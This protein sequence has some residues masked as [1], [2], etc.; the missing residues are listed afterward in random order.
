MMFPITVCS[1]GPWAWGG[2]ADA[3]QT[4]KSKSWLSIKQKPRTL[5]VARTMTQWHLA[6]NQWSLPAAEKRISRTFRAR[7]DNEFSDTR[8][9]CCK[10]KKH[11]ITGVKMGDN[12]SCY[13]WYPE[14][15]SLIH[16]IAPSGLPLLRAELTNWH[17]QN[18]LS[19]NHTRKVWLIYLWI[20]AGRP[21]VDS[22]GV[23]GHIF[24]DK[25][26]NSKLW[27]LGE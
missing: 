9:T 6:T 1:A 26:L 12:F 11:E 10:I 18:S 8:G 13:Q 23:S 3:G 22:T 21:E 19:M 24:T 2:R 15:P 16:L 7:D 20:P 4:K 14:P 25:D 5:P 17:C 27:T